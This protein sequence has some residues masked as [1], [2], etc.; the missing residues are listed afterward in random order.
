MR[1]RAFV[2]GVTLH[3]LSSRIVAGEVRFEEP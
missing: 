1:A 2:D 3:D